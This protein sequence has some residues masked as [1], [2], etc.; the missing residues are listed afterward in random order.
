M[1][2][3]RT[4]LGEKRSRPWILD[5]GFDCLLMSLGGKCPEHMK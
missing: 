4:S 1:R 2:L 3:A 5:D